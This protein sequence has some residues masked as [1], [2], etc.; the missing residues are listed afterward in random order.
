MFDYHFD[1]IDT[2]VK[3]YQKLNKNFTVKKSK[4]SGTIELENGKKIKYGN[5]SVKVH[6]FG[7]SATIKK[8][9]KNCLDFFEP[10]KSKTFEFFYEAKD[11]F[12]EKMTIKDKK[13]TGYFLAN[14]NKE[15]AKNEVVYNIDLSSAYLY[16][17]YNSKKISK[18]IFDKIFKLD[19]I[20]RLVTL[21]L[22]AYQPVISTY[23]NG[24]FVDAEMIK[25]E[26]RNVF[27]YCV[28]EIFY[29]S[30]FV[31]QKIGN[32]FIFS[33]VDGF[34]FTGEKNINVISDFL[35]SKKY[36]FKLCRLF[37]FEIEKKQMYINYKYLKKEKIT[38]QS[39][40]ICVPIFE[41]K[42]NKFFF[43]MNEALKENDLQKIKDIGNEFILC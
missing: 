15:L 30:K 27:F 18:Q 6:A 16:A 41:R 28:R 23:K 35:N 29:L 1:L 3:Q 32:D 24:V 40:I 20:S 22:L 37:N 42:A 9:L 8:E 36:P 31:K 38:M 13:E 26:Y 33:W 39:K 25:N 5:K 21:G 17:L 11:M 4:F 14:E 2:H 19:K 34:Y 12:F 10:E 7:Y 43:E